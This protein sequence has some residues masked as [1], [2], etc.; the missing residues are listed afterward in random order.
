MPVDSRRVT[1]H[2]P[3]VMPAI[4][5]HVITMVAFNFT[6][7]C[8]QK[9]M[10]SGLMR[11]EISCGFCGRLRLTI[12]Q[13][14][15]EQCSRHEESHQRNGQAVSM[16]AEQQREDRPH[17]SHPHQKADKKQPRGSASLRDLSHGPPKSSEEKTAGGGAYKKRDDQVGQFIHD[18]CPP[19]RCF[20]AVLPGPA[21]WYRVR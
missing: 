8:S 15:N 18:V 3:T 11:M 21:G 17:G 12:R 7:P 9:T 19:S 4:N 14:S 6:T 1:H 13:P 20:R 2:A 5:P 16:M 10:L